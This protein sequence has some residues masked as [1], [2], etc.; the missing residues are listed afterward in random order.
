MLKVDYENLGKEIFRK[1]SS[2]YNS[3]IFYSLIK[4][5]IENGAKL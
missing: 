4:K 1:H 5:G 3:Q 2:V